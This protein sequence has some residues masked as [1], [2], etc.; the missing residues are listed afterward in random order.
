[1]EGKTDPRHNYS[2]FYQRQDF[3]YDK[4]KY[5]LQADHRTGLTLDVE[6]PKITPLGQS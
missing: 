4:Q 5:E 3:T 2:K 1:M 6:D